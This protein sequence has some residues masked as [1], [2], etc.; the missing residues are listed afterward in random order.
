MI[1]AITYQTV[2]RQRRKS[3]VQDLEDLDLADL[4]PSRTSSTSVRFRCRKS[5]SISS[6]KKRMMVKVSAFQ[7]QLKILVRT[8]IPLAIHVVLG[9]T[10]KQGQSLHLPLCPLRPPPLKRCSD[11]NCKM[12][13]E[14]SKTA[15]T[16]SDTIR[17]CSCL[18]RWENRAL[19]ARSSEDVKFLS[20]EN[21]FC[22]FSVTSVVPACWA[23]AAWNSGVRANDVFSVQFLCFLLD[24]RCSKD[25]FQYVSF[26]VLKASSL[27][28][29]SCCSRT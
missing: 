16:K 19:D 15:K 5:W 17:M 21:G 4:D 29:S 27:S 7:F 18:T 6:C 26:P 11:D 12:L 3:G 1:H 20:L 13:S 23:S 2:K 28:C 14:K 24:G 25:L 10:V 8:N 9:W 22:A